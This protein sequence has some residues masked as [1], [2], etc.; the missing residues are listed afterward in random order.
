MIHCEI[1]VYLTNLLIPAPPPVT[2][3]KSLIVLEVLYY[4]HAIIDKTNIFSG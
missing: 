2:R 4:D 3:H 1:Q